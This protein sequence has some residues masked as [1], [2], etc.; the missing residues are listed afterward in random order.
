MK[1]AFKF[2]CS[3]IFGLSFAHANDALNLN[4]K[5]AILIDLNTHTV[6]YEKEA[7]TLADPSSMSKIMTIY[8]VFD[9]LKKGM[10]SPE[11]MVTISE[12]AWKTE[13]SRMFVNV[14]SKVSVQDLL[15]GVIVQSGNDASVALAEWIGGSE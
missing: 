11:T 5:Q 13:G 9:A 3:I 4:A 14:G 7:D 12:K 15:R 10:L 2:F 8:M 1:Q 6:L